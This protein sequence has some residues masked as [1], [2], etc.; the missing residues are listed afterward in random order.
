MERFT[1]YIV[2]QHAS[3]SATA[4]TSVPIPAD[5]VTLQNELLDIQS[6]LEQRKAKLR[7]DEERT[8][9]WSTAKAKSK[10]KEKERPPGSTA[11]AG[12]GGLAAGSTQISP[13]V[14]KKA[15]SRLKREDSR[16]S[17]QTRP[18]HSTDCLGA[19]WSLVL[20]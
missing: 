5:L 13:G 10:G 2:R 3:T 14:D 7:A 6:G 19:S 9:N 11:A 12:A 1:P 16:Q 15:T 8:R 18:V 20:R 17:A 4:A